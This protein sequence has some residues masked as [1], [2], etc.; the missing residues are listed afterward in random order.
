MVESMRDFKGVIVFPS[1]ICPRKLTWVRK[2]CD[3]TGAAYMFS[4]SGIW[5]SIS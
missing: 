1:I 4:L 2:K 3:L 5:F